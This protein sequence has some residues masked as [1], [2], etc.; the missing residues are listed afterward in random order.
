MKTIELVVSPQGK[1]TLETKGFAGESCRQASLFLE[2]ALG[3][4]ATDQ[5]TAESFAA[6]DQAS[7]QQPS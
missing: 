3:V 5:P 2:A 4:R 7:L 6:V 1:T